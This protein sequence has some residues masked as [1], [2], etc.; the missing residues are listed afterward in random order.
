MITCNCK[1]LPS[2][3]ELLQL[4]LF[5][6]F[7][8]IPQKNTGTFVTDVMQMFFKSVKHLFPLNI[9]GFE[10]WQLLQL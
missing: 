10:I 6:L 9:K 8:V 2:L 4:L 1:Y 7:L 5:A 3:L